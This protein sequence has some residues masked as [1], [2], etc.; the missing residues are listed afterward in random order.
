MPRPIGFILGAALGALSSG[1]CVRAPGVF[2]NWEVPTP[3]PAAVTM[4]TATTPMQLV[5][6]ASATPPAP[7]AGAVRMSQ[8]SA[9]RILLDEAH[10][11]LAQGDPCDAI[12]HLERHRCSFGAPI[13]GEERD[14]MWIEALVKGAAYDD[15]RRRAA[16]FGDRFPDSIFLSGVESAI[17]AIPRSTSASSSRAV[18]P[19]P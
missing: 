6:A 4:A 1:W 10:A 19:A 9:E 15:A 17:A 14:A 13:L 7:A 2:A 12:V 8:L 5:P 11:A 16:A 18:L 3:S